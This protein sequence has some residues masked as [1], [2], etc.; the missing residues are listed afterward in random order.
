MVSY[1]PSFGTEFE[2][3]YHRGTISY[4]GCHGEYIILKVNA[5]RWSSLPG[6]AFVEERI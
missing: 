3:V 5:Q 2:L 4:V 1:H 6:S